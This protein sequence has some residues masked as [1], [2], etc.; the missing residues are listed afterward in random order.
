MLMC[1]DD[2]Q[3]CHITY[4]FTEL[5]NSFSFDFKGFLP[6]TFVSCYSE[7]VCIVSMQCQYSGQFLDLWTPL[8]WHL[9]TDFKSL[10]ST[11]KNTHSISSSI[12]IQFSMKQRSATLNIRTLQEIDFWHLIFRK[13]WI[14]SIWFWFWF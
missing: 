2:I 12:I 8:C 4:C 7:A 14:F 9:M 1:F 11:R 5:H 3:C 10:K 13:K 6:F